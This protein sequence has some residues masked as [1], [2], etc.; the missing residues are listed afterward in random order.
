[1]D[2]F[3]SSF[4]VLTTQIG[5]ENQGQDLNLTTKSTRYQENAKVSSPNPRKTSPANQI[6]K[7]PFTSCPFLKNPKEKV[8]RYFDESHRV[9][10]PFSSVQMD[11]WFS[12]GYLFNE[13]LISFHEESPFISLIDFLQR[14]EKLTQSTKSPK[15][16]NSLAFR[17]N[18]A[19]RR[20]LKTVKLLAFEPIEEL[21][22]DDEADIS[23]TNIGIRIQSASNCRRFVN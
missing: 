22:S 14:T 17:R 6:Y 13:L 12:K 2:S 10:G 3:S 16:V 1:M 21:S 7:N 15:A 19:C 9:Q 23:D 18:K 8:W 20:I 11:F 4:S 5:H